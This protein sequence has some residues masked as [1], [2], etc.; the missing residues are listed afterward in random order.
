M[1][2]SK[3]SEDLEKFQNQKRNYAIYILQSSS[4]LNTS[5]KIRKTNFRKTDSIL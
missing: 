5:G 4:N 1:P 2:L 3:G